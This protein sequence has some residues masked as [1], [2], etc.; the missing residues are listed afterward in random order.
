MRIFLT[1][2]MF[3]A[4]LT[5][6]G[7]ASAPPA[8]QLPGAAASEFVLSCTSFAALTPDALAQRF[9]AENVVTQT[10]P[11]AE[12]ETYEATVVFPNDVTRRLVLVWNEA[13]TAPASVGIENAG[14]QWRGA[15]GYTI[16]TPI[17]EIER[18]N[19][20]PF[21]LW[22]FGWD[23]GGWVSDWSAGV[24]SQNPICN[25]RIRFTPRGEPNTNAM[26]DREFSSNEPAIRAADPIVSEFGLTIGAPSQ[27]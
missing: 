9:G 25:T 22:G 10:L 24:L 12:G 20:M 7:Q 16:G 27:Q 6:C 8:P 4:L 21:K 3:A 14:T 13:R 26:G 19:V 23:Y 15:E 5:A 17:G 18:I 2:V 1:T 11:G